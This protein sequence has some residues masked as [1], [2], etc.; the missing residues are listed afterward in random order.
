MQSELYNQKSTAACCAAKKECMVKPLNQLVATNAVQAAK[1][2]L[3]IRSLH[4]TELA[5]GPVQDTE[6]S[7][8]LLSAK[9]AIISDQRQWHLYAAPHNTIFR[10]KADSYLVAKQPPLE[11]DLGPVH[12][13]GGP[14][15][16]S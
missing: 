6:R 9:A 11:K 8:R 15:C 12:R 14:R 2:P 5:V 16:A 4:I 3:G 7:T 13:E 10:G 1:F